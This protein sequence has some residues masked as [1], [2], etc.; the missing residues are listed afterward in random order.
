MAIAIPNINVPSPPQN[1]GPQK[2]SLGS[3]TQRQVVEQN[4]APVQNENNVPQ[5][6]VQ[7]TAETSVPNKVITNNNFQTVV[8]TAQNLLLPNTPEGA[9][10][11]IVEGDTLGKVQPAGLVAENI[12][13]VLTEMLMLII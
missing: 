13:N 3:N 6:Q 10:S 4:K 12:L 2:P 8:E 1:N 9:N 11:L 5:S 7:N